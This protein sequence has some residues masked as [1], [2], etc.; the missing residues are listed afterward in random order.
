MHS[1]NFVNG[2]VAG[3]QKREDGFVMFASVILEYCQ[4]D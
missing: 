2:N 3:K 4:Q 1:S